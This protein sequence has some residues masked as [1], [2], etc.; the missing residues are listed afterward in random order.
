L[1]SVWRDARSERGTRTRAVTGWCAICEVVGNLSVL[2][3]D[4]EK[5]FHFVEIR[6]RLAHGLCGTRMG[7]LS[8]RTPQV[9]P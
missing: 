5:N 7:G 3:S 1:G 2:G 6:M 4:I 9:L 8:P